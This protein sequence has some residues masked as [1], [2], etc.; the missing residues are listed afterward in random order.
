MAR[1]PHPPAKLVQVRQPR[2]S[3]PTPLP[4][5]TLPQRHPSQWELRG[6]APDDFPLL[7]SGQPLT[8]STSGCSGDAIMIT[9][10]LGQE[11]KPADHQVPERSPTRG[12]AQKAALTALPYLRSFAE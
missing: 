9:S 11:L 8:I 5:L 6:R 3:V 7:A 2:G 4:I 12:N 10:G 1:P